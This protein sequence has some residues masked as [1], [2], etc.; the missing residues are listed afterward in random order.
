MYTFVNPPTEFIAFPFW[1]S[2]AHFSHFQLSISSAFPLLVY[3]YNAINSQC[4]LKSINKLNKKKNKETFD[5]GVF[6]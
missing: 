4:C 6:F 3:F 5:K 1:K 2:V